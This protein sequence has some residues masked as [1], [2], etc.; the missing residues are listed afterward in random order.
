MA[1]RKTKQARKREARDM[2]ATPAPAQETRLLPAYLERRR[3]Q[4]EHDAAQRQL[5]ATR[6]AEGPSESERRLMTATADSLPGTKYDWHLDFVR[7]VQPR[8]FDMRGVPEEDP[9]LINRLM[10]AEVRAARQKHD[11]AMA[12][13]EKHAPAQAAA[14]HSAFTGEWSAMRLWATADALH[15]TQGSAAE[16]A[17]WV[18]SAVA[19][20]VACALSVARHRLWAAVRHVLAAC[21]GIVPEVVADY[22]TARQAAIRKAER[23]E[24]ARR[25]KAIEQG[26]VGAGDIRR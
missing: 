8:K 9:R 2:A 22:A 19:D 16:M 20:S 6:K 17:A 23:E 24:R 25:W 11:L 18:E 1:S 21:D 10:A 4:G 12:A 15:D 26:K 14:Y 7:I 13:L 3:R 5:R